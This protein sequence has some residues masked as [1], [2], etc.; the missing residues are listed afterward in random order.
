MA[1]R[2]VFTKSKF[3]IRKILSDQVG[4]PF[5]VNGETLGTVNPTDPYKGLVSEKLGTF[6]Y[7]DCQ[8]ATANLRSQGISVSKMDA[9]EL[10]FKLGNTDG[11]DIK[12]MQNKL[13]S[14][15]TSWSPSITRENGE[16]VMSFK[17]ISHPGGR[18]IREAPPININSPAGS[19]TWLS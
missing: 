9:E 7:Q 16:T 1:G 17:P 15:Y 13:G 14:T 12:D 2:C 19:S 4:I 3:K 10:K 5:K 18:E 8:T 11:K 6:G